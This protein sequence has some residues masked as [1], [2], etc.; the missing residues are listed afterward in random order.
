[1]IVYLDE[2]VVGRRTI[3]IGSTGA[4][5]QLHLDG[6]PAR[7]DAYQLRCSAVSGGQTWT[8]DTDLFYLPT[9]T[10]GS[11]VKVDRRTGGL[12]A[13]RSAKVWEHILPVGWYD[14]S[15]HR[16]SSR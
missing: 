10:M 2:Q 7:T 1:M 5:L 14:V 6:S 4:S 16:V 13:R 11:V 3:D 9:R 8:D 12:L 15:Q